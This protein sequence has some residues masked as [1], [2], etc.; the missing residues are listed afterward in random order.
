MPLRCT[1]TSRFDG[2]ESEPDLRGSEAGEIAPGS[3]RCAS[4]SYEID[5]FDAPGAKITV[6]ID[7]SEL[8][9]SIVSRAARGLP[10][11][12]RLADGTNVIVKTGDHLML[13]VRRSQV[14]TRSHRLAL[15]PEDSRATCAV[16]RLFLREP[17]SAVRTRSA[18]FGNA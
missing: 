3:L 4:I 11:T 15:S 13:I 5:G 10:T 14:D 16:F 9:P 6:R 18:S 1:V 12:V 8:D 17:S 2:K 7:D